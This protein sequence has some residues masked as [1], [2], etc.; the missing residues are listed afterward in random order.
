[1]NQSITLPISN[2]SS[3]HTND[4]NFVIFT[5][6]CSR[7]RQTSILTFIYAH[8]GRQPST[9]TR[10]K[11]TFVSRK[12]KKNKWHASRIVEKTGIPIYSS[13]ICNKLFIMNSNHHSYKNMA[14]FTYLSFRYNQVQNIFFHG[15]NQIN[16]YIFAENNN[17]C[18]KNISIPRRIHN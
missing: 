1:M 4:L 17:K 12:E 2:V 11:K 8:N 5:Y 9:I 14:Q 13:V 6:L 15:D 16:T 10:F 18:N 3:S 7:F